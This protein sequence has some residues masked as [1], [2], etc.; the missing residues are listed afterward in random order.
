MKNIMNAT[1]SAGLQNLHDIVP[2]SPVPW[3]PPAAGWYFAGAAVLIVLA[4]IAW[5]TFRRWQANACRR[6]ALK[7]LKELT[8]RL[9]DNE[10]AARKLPELVKRT[11][12]CAWPRR[13]V[14]G[15]SGMSWL[16]TAFFVLGL[17]C[18]APGA[19]RRKGRSGSAKPRTR[20]TAESLLSLFGALAVLIF[21]GAFTALG[22]SASSFSPLSSFSASGFLW[23]LYRR[24]W[25]HG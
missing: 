2:V 17:A 8:E 15:L 6:A 19:A 23:D 18:Y 4:W 3:W 1:D 11:A 12:L 21:S 5:A 25:S 10:N 9:P 14:A 16:E 7:E 13:Q 24:F 22:A 20:K